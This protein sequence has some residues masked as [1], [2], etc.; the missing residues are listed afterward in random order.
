MSNAGDAKK[1][2]RLIKKSAKDLLTPYENM[3][4]R[5]QKQWDDAANRLLTELRGRKNSR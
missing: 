2:E 1:R 5:R 3:S 4:P